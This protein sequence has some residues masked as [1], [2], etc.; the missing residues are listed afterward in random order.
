MDDLLNGVQKLNQKSKMQF[1]W[2]YLTFWPQI[3]P[4]IQ[5]SIFFPTPVNNRSKHGFLHAI[6]GQNQSQFWYTSQG[7][8]SALKSQNTA[9]PYM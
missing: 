6:K 1:F 2:P 5:N 9:K 7:L 8:S 3:D 4:Q